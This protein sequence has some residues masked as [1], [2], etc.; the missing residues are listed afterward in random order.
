M[1]QFHNRPFCP[2]SPPC[3]TAGDLQWW[4]SRLV[5]PTLARPTPSPAPIINASAY[6]DA[7][8]ETGIGI[9]VGDKWRAWRLLPGWKADTRDIG[10][11]EAVGFL[12]L[13]LT[14]SP[15]VPKGSHVKV[16]RDNRGVVEGWW[17]GRSR[18]RAINE[19]FKWL[20]EHLRRNATKSSFHT[21]Y[22]RTASNPADAPS[23][24]IYPS[25]SFLLRLITLPPEL[26]RFIVDSQLPFTP[27]KYRARE[28]G[29]YSNT[30]TR[31]F[32]DTHQRD[33]SRTK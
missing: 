19:V 33:S 26:E 17:N 2:H 22:V 1:A 25:A 32:D 21:A 24:G 14:L 8:S 15:T 6:L 20:H 30:A 23:R 18:N 13:T 9:T 7:S 4:K 5:Q 3:R 16:F 10:W 31:W 29:L 11:A 27:A 28:R 12:L